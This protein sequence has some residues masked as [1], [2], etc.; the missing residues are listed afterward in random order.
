MIMLN[1]I[2]VDFTPI[3]IVCSLNFFNHTLLCL[4]FKNNSFWMNFSYPLRMEMQHWIFP[5]DVN[6]N[7]FFITHDYTIGQQHTAA[8]QEIQPSVSVQQHTINRGGL[9]PLCSKTSDTRQR[10][11]VC[12]C[13]AVCVLPPIFSCRTTIPHAEM[14]PNQQQAPTEGVTSVDTKASSSHS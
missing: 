11:R 9:P 10:L 1:F 8:Q 3:L 5:V 7:V 4:S 14:Q 13:A 6:K 2:D 12:S